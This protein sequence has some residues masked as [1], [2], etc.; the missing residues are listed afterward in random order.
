M[1]VPR[2]DGWL[3]EPSGSA[4]ATIRV[5]SPSA[6]SASSWSPD[7]TTIRCGSGRPGSAGAGCGG[8]ESSGRRWLPSTP[9]SAIFVVLVITDVGDW[10]G[11]GS[12]PDL[13]PQPPAT[14]ADTTAAAAATRAQTTPPTV[15]PGTRA[16]VYD[17]L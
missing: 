10:R 4:A 6:H 2:Y 1:T 8:H 7:N 11:A 16:N 12:C 3:D 5:C 17:S 15:T 9:A 14:S 13:A